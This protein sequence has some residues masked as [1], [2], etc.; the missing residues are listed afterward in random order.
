MPSPTE[1]LV[2]A[3]QQ[4]RA[5]AFVD[6]IAQYEAAIAAA[7][8]SNDLAQLAEAL[9]RLAVLR[10]H[11]DDTAQA[12][13]LC[14]RSYE[15]ARALG[16]DLLAAEALNTLG[17][18]EMTSDWLED[19]RKDF[20]QAL[21]LGGAY[22]SL[23]AKVEQNLGILA[24]IQ[25][26][27]DEAASRYAR[28]LV[29]CRSGGD[30]RGCA[31]AYH[32]LGM[33][34]ADRERYDEAER[35]FQSSLEISERTGDVYLKGLTLGEV[36]EAH[37]ER[38]RFEDARR[39]A[40]QALAIFDQLGAGSEKAS[41]YRVIGSVYRETG[42][43]ALA[44]ARLDAALEAAV[45]AGS[46]LSEAEASR[47]LALLYQAMGRNREAFSLLTAAHRLF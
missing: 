4:E 31:R 3:Q 29:A 33:V 36:A 43:P 25:G 17:G 47:E 15:V 28:A 40:E 19:A 20:L 8:R 30:E 11:R 45:A 1:L 46:L 12:R 44:E 6:A 32:N 26:D 39:T 22:G 41:V 35:Y 5:G 7:E 10:H 18:V 14:R 16:D 38:Q 34:S 13:G 24:N 9:R 21:E 23:R 27:L 42:R 2:A 37:L